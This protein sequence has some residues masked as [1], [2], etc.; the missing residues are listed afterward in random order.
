M[1][2]FKR[3]IAIVLAFLLL[4]SG[5]LFADAAT[6]STISSG[7]SGTTGACT[8]QFVTATGKFIVTGNG[9][10]GSDVS[11]WSD[12]IS[13]IKS[14]EICNGVTSIPDKAFMN[15]SNVTEI[16]ISN[17]VTSIGS[18][19]FS[20]RYVKNLTIPDS[21][22]T[23]GNHAF[24][25]CTN[26]EEI[27]M[28]NG[29]KSVGV[30][31]FYHWS[32][33]LKK[34]YIK[35]ITSWCNINFDDGYANPLNRA[36]YLY[37]NDK[38]V[39][40]LVIP[41]GVTT[42]KDYAFVGASINSVTI[43]D[44]VTKIGKSAFQ[45][46]DNL[47]TIRLPHSITDI[48]DSA[49]YSSSNI[50]NV[51][52]SGSQAEWENIEFG[53]NNETLLDSTITYNSNYPTLSSCTNTLTPPDKINISI[54]SS[55]TSLAITPETSGYYII[56]TDKTDYTICGTLY[57]Y[58]NN[59]EVSKTST[60]SNNFYVKEYLEGGNIYYIQLSTT[61]GL[62][63]QTTIYI[64]DENTLPTEPT[65][66]PTTTA[67]VGPTLPTY[68]TFHVV[69]GSPEL[70]NGS[71]W[72]P[73]DAS[74]LMAETSDG[75]YEIT[76][77]N[78]P[79]GSYQ[80]K[81]T[82]GGAWDIADYNLTGKANF[83]GAN[84]IITVPTDES[85]V[86]ITFTESD[87][88]VKVFING[89]Q[90]GS[91]TEPATTTPTTA[92]TTEK[93]ET[94]TVNYGY[95]VALPKYATTTATV[96]TAT[97]TTTPVTTEPSTSVTEPTET[98]KTNSTAKKTTVTLKNSS[99]KIYISEKTTIKATVKNGKGKTTYKSSNSKVAK[100]DNKG[101]VTGLKKGTATITVTNNKV[102]KSFKV[103][104]KKP[105]LNSTSKKLKVGKTFNLKIIGK[106]GK[107]T[108]SSSNKKVVTVTK[109]GKVKA[110]KSGTATIKVKTNGIT[111]RCKVTVPKVTTNYKK[112]VGTWKAGGN[113]VVIKSVK[114]NKIE[115]YMISESSDFG[116]RFADTE[117]ETGNTVTGTI[118][119][120]VV[121][122]KFVDSWYN[123]GI[124]TLKFKGNYIEAK[125]KITYQDP[126][127]NFSLNI[128][129]K[130]Y[131]K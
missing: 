15:G 26:L 32:N 44:S 31:G 28:G 4:M 116:G 68:G 93:K 16:S 107:A 123:K 38:Y 131:K 3:S 86:K 74:N 18:Y 23:I 29:L 42:I 115:V 85:T 95:H 110:V 114:N 76:Y 46:C 67:P 82:T 34:V 71:S 65:T 91:A 10:M 14:I 33:N 98:T 124:C 97:A 79:A 6:V 30:F 72:N 81:V 113:K 25:G 125:T 41:D 12:Y 7:A 17:T 35:D 9:P 59:K 117:S 69:A 75:V 121:K 105:T 90:V 62:S 108:Y 56:C 119:N 48:E 45:D 120:G 20:G 118:H 101:K 63:C 100:V 24:Y 51:L 127:A 43:P 96:T 50:N 78:V 94:T 88:F 64:G 1:K 106:V 102:S 19:A 52:F 55:G 104:V 36:K 99:A 129:G 84:A 130:L 8:W 70:C 60:S 73:A 5:T 22:E 49:F 58:Y 89:V 54:D 103:T 111:L 21:V 61:N 11:D 47:Q 37:L 40:N 83:G 122:L 2:N 87:D 53:E 80:F 57:D 27:T 112:Y 92:P 109:S 66:V 128:N 126:M 13:R 77:T 39:E